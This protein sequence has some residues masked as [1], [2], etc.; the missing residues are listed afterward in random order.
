MIQVGIV[1]D[2]A[3]VR[4]GQRDYLSEQI[5]LREVGEAATGREAIDLV[6]GTELDVLV[7]DLS[8]P[9]QSGIDALATFEVRKQQSGSSEDLRCDFGVMGERKRL[10][11]TG[12][13]G[14]GNHVHR[15]IPRESRKDR[16]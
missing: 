3:I 12:R 15:G 6:R 4:S 7:M 14:C 8:M 2:H 16:A 5:D 1:D 11:S 9:D 10:G 13:R